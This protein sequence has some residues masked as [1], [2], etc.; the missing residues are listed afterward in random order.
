MKRLLLV[1]LLMGTSMNGA[2]VADQANRVVEITSGR[3]VWQINLPDADQ[4]IF[5]NTGVEFPGWN[6]TVDVN[7]HSLPV[8]SKLIYTSGGPPL[9]TVSGDAPQ[10]FTAPHL[11]IPGIEEAKGME[12]S[13]LPEGEPGTTQVSYK[14][15]REGQGLAL[16]AVNLLG[17]VYDI[18]ANTWLVSEQLT[19]EIQSDLT[20][21]VSSPNDPIYLNQALLHILMR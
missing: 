6:T 11:I 16:W 9:I 12:L 15:I 13:V 1:T 19:V 10:M 4:I 7:G 14:L 17:A 21:S 8:L 18:S 20:G 5:T 3:F 2:S